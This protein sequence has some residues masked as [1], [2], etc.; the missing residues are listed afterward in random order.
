[1]EARRHCHWGSWRLRPSP[2]RESG[3]KGVRPEERSEL[4]DRLLLSSL[5]AQAQ[6]PTHTATDTPTR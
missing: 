4:Y 3:D 6:Q 2:A 1:V 5:D